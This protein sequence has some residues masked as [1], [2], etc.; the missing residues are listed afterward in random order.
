MRRGNRY[1]ALL[2]CFVVNERVREA[3]LDPSQQRP[4]LCIGCVFGIDVAKQHNPDTF[5]AQV[6]AERLDCWTT[7]LAHREHV[8]KYF[9]FANGAEQRIDCNA[10][11]MCIG[12]KM[13]TDEHATT[14]ASSQKLASDP[15]RSITMRGGMR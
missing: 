14:L 4:H 2:C 6:I 12:R 9:P 15:R 5:V 8:C 13:L 11:C 7:H 1:R 3:M 10:N